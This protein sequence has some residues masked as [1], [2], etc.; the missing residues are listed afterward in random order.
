LIVKQVKNQFQVKNDHL[1]HYR[2]KVWEAIE[3]F[4]A[5]SIKSVPHEKN[6]KADSLA[7]S[8]SLMIPH[9]EFDQDKYTI[10][11][12]FRPSVPDNAE[13]WQVFNDDQKIITFLEKRDNFEQ[14]YFE[15]SDYAF[16]E[17]TTSPIQ[18]GVENEDP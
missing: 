9:S 8:A 16:H 2:N 18:E 6:D 11:M 14:L 12:V 4:D 5:F 17:S 7:V 13:N 15:G 10:E 1:R 3:V